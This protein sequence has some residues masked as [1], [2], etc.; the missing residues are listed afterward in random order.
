MSDLI[1]RGALDLEQ[2]DGNVISWYATG[3]N[4][5]INNIKAAPTVDAEPVRHGEWVQ[6]KHRIFGLP[7]DYIC[8]VC[9]CDYAL[10]EYKYCPSCGARMDGGKQ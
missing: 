9:G 10:A 8:S 5:A 3:W 4:D 1:D 7:Y 6:K 2:Y